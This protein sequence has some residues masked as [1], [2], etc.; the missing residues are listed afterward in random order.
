MVGV[1]CFPDRCGYPG[2]TCDRWDCAASRT[3]LQVLVL[4]V[5]FTLVGTSPMRDMTGFLVTW[6]FIIAMIVIGFC[7]GAGGKMRRTY[8]ADLFWI[9]AQGDEADAEE[10]E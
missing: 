5:A 1:I 10:E 8:V 6:Y 9:P 4:S 7:P 3:D 2:A